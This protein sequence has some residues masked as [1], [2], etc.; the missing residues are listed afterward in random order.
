MKVKLNQHQID[1]AGDEQIFRAATTNWNFS[2]NVP[3]IRSKR[4]SPK[5]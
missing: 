2:D 5:L 3:K 4:I 1:T